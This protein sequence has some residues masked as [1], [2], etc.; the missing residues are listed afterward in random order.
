ME[1]PFDPDPQ[2]GH[3]AEAVARVAMGVV[4]G[5]TPSAEIRF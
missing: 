4:M 2:T 3:G 5:D 1:Q